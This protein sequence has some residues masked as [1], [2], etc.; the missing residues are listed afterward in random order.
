MSAAML[1]AA[2]RWSQGEEIRRACPVAP[3]SPGSKMPLLP[4]G[5]NGSGGYN[6]ATADADQIRA[7]WSAVPEAGV[8]IHLARAGLVVLDVEGESKGLDPF[9]VIAAIHAAGFLLPRTRLH[10]TPGGGFHYLFARAAGREA[11][12]Y[13]T[14]V[15]DTRG[16]EIRRSGVVLVPPSVVNGRPYTVANDATV[17]T[18]PGWM[19]APRPTRPPAS[20]P[21]DDKRAAVVL[22]R[23]AEEVR[24]APEGQ[25][26]HTLCKAAF[27]VGGL[28]GAGRLDMET[29]KAE[30]R[31]AALAAGHGLTDGRPDPG[32]ERTMDG[33]LDDALV[34]G[35]LS[36]W[37]GES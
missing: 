17:V 24:S 1:D 32:A 4:A 8:A 11:G 30:L 6:L 28:V 10:R 29:A 34:R 12:D 19:L 31:A 26:N 33:T 27:A 37:G 7:W 18:A 20:R 35:A 13:R 15:P 22:A 36:P 14:S 2:L 3:A 23:Q 16:V 5:P 9:D 25:L 21:I